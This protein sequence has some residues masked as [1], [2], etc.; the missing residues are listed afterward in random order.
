MSF[1]GIPAMRVFGVSCLPL[2][3]EL[4]ATMQPSA[5]LVDFAIFAHEPIH[6]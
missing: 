3:R 1:A 2:T 6:T 4:C 5:M